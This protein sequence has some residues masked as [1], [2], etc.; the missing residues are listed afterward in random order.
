MFILSCITTIS[1]NLYFKRVPCT[2]KIHR[3]T[4][5]AD[6]GGSRILIWGQ[7]GS[8][9]RFLTSKQSSFGGFWGNKKTSCR[10]CQHLNTVPISALKKHFLRIS[11]ITKCITEIVNAECYQM[12]N[13]L[14]S[15]VIFWLRA[16]APPPHFTPI[17]IYGA[18]PP[19]WN[20]KYATEWICQTSTKWSSKVCVSTCCGQGDNSP[21]I[22]NIQQ[23]AVQHT[24]I[25]TESNKCVSKMLTR[26]T[27]TAKPMYS[28]TTPFSRPTFTVTTAIYLLPC[29]TLTFDLL[30]SK[31]IVSRPCPL[32]TCAN[33][34]Q[35][36]SIIFK[37]SSWQVW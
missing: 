33:L 11:N 6:Y 4:L 2:S 29:V 19:H 9:A 23:Q 3:Q 36:C 32:T 30:T 21:Q 18:S 35:I 34:L 7:A 13:Q 12:D 5:T 17:G 15:V 37:I 20:P 31:L 25:H 22:H 1:F 24:T 27:G 28:T 8:S 10:G 14:Y 26:H 16:A